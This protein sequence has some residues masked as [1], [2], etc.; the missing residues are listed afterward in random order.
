MEAADDQLFL[1]RI[2]VDVAHRE[3]AG[4]LR[5]VALG[6]DRHLLALQRQPPVGD[7][8]EPLDAFVITTSGCGTTIKDYGNLFPG[9]PDAARVAA[10]AK[11]VTEVL[12]TLGLDPAVD[13]DAVSVFFDTE[14]DA[15]TFVDL[16][17]PGVVGTAFVTAYCLD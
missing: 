7:R 4:Q 10:L 17:Q 13:Y 14:A 2:G 15:Q 16:Y 12:E 6:V 9:D 3:H 11:D 5:L 1:A 8:A